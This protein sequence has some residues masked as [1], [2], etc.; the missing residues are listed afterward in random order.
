MLL[1][2]STALSILEGSSINFKTRFAALLF[3]SAKERMRILFTVVNAVSAEEKY[4]D[5][6][7]KIIIISIFTASLGPKSSSPFVSRVVMDYFPT[8]VSDYLLYS[9][10]DQ[11]AKEAAGGD[12][13]PYNGYELLGDDWAFPAI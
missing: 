5:N 2:I 6:M 7:S 10:Y 12:T 3:S 8:I 1:Q 9:G 4:A 11:R 13:D